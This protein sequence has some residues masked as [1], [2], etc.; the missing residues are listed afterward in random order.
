MAKPQFRITKNRTDQLERLNKSVRSKQSRLKRL[1][2]V[3]ISNEIRSI[4]DFNSSV[5][6]NNYVKTLESFTDYNAYRYAEL[7]SGEVVEYSN[8]KKLQQEN[9]KRN[10]VNRDR[11][12]KSLTIINKGRSEKLYLKDF[13]ENPDLYS[14]YNV[15]SHKPVDTNISVIKDR[16]QYGSSIKRAV[17]SAQKAAKSSTYTE[18]QK[19][20][21]DN[22]LRSVVTEFSVFKAHKQLLRYVRGKGIRWFNAQYI[23]GAIPVFE[24]MYK[25]EDYRRRF[26]G[27]MMNFGFTQTDN[28]DYW[29]YPDDRFKKTH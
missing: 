26:I 22:F 15:S 8:L 20:N 10:K 16:Y 27:T 17:E 18:R 11:L 3:D 19:Q 14:E 4:N 9:I 25:Y 23:S 29:I 1:Y 6:Y 5:E 2:N 24:Y 28:F 12:K 21:Y 13:D 7:P